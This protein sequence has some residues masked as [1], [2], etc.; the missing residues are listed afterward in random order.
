[1]D[2]LENLFYLQAKYDT[3]SDLPVLMDFNAD[4]IDED[5][6]TLDTHYTVYEDKQ[7]LNI[8]GSIIKKDAKLVDYIGIQVEPPELRQAVIE[9]YENNSS[10]IHFIDSTIE[11]ALGDGIQVRCVDFKENKLV[12]EFSQK[13]L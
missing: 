9:A 8:R 12:V 10:T 4:I 6:M 13:N 11:A 3:S 2:V 1:M 7:E 5:I